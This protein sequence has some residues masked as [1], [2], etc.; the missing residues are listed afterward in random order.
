MNTYVIH[1]KKIETDI[2]C[3]EAIC[4]VLSSDVDEVYYSKEVD[5]N[6]YMRIVWGVALK[7]ANDKC[8]FL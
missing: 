2:Q 6:K 4:E 3:I 5:N 7:K 8:K 1:L